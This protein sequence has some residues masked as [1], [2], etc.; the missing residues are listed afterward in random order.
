[1][2]AHRIILISYL[3]IILVGTLLLYLP[4]STKDGISLIDA[5]FTATSATTVTGL[6]VM[7][8]EKAFTPFGKLVILVLIQIGGLGY[9][10]FTTY[11]L[12]TFRKKVS[13]RDRVILAEAM[14]YPGLYGLVRFL[15]RTIPLVF[16]IEFVGAL[17][18]FPGFLFHSKN[19]GESLVMSVFH[20]VSAFNNAG[21]SLLSSNLTPFVGN[22]WMNLILSLLIILGGLGFYVLYEMI[23]YFR[24]EVNR[25]S[26]HTKLVLLSSGVLILVGFL[27]LLLEFREWKNLSLV[28]KLTASFFQSVSARTAG[29]NTV[30]VAKLSE[31]SLFW[32]VILMFIGASPGGTGGGI[33]T[34]TATV[35]LISVISYIRGKGQVVIFGRRLTEDIINKAMIILSLSFAYVTF[36]SLIITELEGGKLLPVLFEVVSAFSTVGLSVGTPEGLS[37]SANFSTIGKMLIIITMLMGRIGVLSFMLAIYGKGEESR[38]RP[39]EARI[40]L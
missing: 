17:L 3:I 20:S 6:I 35:I 38:V 14:D 16:F 15:K 37:L 21:F 5:L 1:M 32:L 40:L 10:V 4:I 11:F 31:A 30:D 13:F 22:L 9:M 12:V 23:L 18:L 24:K 33:K 7:D 36:A 27:V 8:T 34:T 25:L 29:F 2:T 26:T 28:E 39:P 19:P